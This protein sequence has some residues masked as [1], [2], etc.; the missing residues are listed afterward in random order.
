MIYNLQMLKFFQRSLTFY[1]SLSYTQ[2]TEI[3]KILSMEHFMHKKQLSIEIVKLF[4]TFFLFLCLSFLVHV[5]LILLYSKIGK[6]FLHECSI[7][8]NMWVEMRISIDFYAAMKTTHI[9]QH[10]WNFKFQKI[11]V[12]LDKK[13]TTKLFSTLRRC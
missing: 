1:L 8:R 6:I 4:N 13:N 11:I 3:L 12:F 7:K 5:I 9:T 2:H 10:C